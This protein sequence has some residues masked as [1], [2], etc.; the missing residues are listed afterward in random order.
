MSGLANR[1]ATLSRSSGWPKAVRI[2]TSRPLTELPRTTLPRIAGPA[3]PAVS[4]KLFGSAE[5]A[6]P[7]LS[8]TVLKAIEGRDDSRCKGAIDCRLP[9]ISTWPPP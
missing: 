5:I 2:L 4:S 7:A 6:A 8:L 9:S 1:A 3:R